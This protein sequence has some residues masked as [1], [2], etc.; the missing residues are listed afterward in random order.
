[1]SGSKLNRRSFLKGAALAAGGLLVAC[2]PAAPAEPGEQPADNPPAKEGVLLRYW[3]QW[4]GEGYQK[5]WDEIQ[6]LDG[7]KEILGN[8][9]FEVKLA[10]AEEPMLTAVAGGDPP[11]TATNINYLGFMARDILLPLDDLLAASTETKP[12][13]FLDGNWGI[14]TY[15]GKQYG[16]P[17]QE[18]FLRFAL[19]Y[20]SQAV[21]EAGLDPNSPPETWDDLLVWQEKLTTRDAAGNLTRIGI[22]PYGA[23]GEGFWDMDGWMAPTSWGWTWFDNA[24]RKFNLNSPEMVEVFT[25]FKKFIDVAGVDNMAAMYS[26]EGRDTWGGAYNAGVEAALIEGYWHPGETA[27]SA[28]DVS[29]VNRASWL[30]VPTSRKGVKVQGAGGHLWTMFKGAKNPEVMFKVGEFLNTNE[31]SMILWNTQGWLP[32]AKSFLD[33]VDPAKYPGLDFYFK[34]AKEATEWHS[35]ARCEITAFASTEYLA[36]KESVNRGEMTPEQAAE[37]MQ[38]RCE[39]EYKNAGFAA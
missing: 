2:A 27:F 8:N 24:T 16:F 39:E 36:L 30:P 5:C 28:P 38:S 1:M 37:Q 22:N 12:E 7:F 20:N 34:S 29:A 4:G 26:A 35:A 21:E 15:K 10:V 3:S 6:A 23:M 33:T 17:S 19:N 11:E 25:T 18:C 31:P 13:K 9:T 32:A 14:G